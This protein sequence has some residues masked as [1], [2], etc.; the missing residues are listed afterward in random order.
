MD[1]RLLLFLSGAALASSALRPAR[2]QTAPAP[3][4][5]EQLDQ[6]LAPIALYPDAL[7]SQVLMAAT[8]PLEVVEAA[9]WSTSNPGLKGQDAV[10]AVQAFDWDVSV[11]SLVAFPEVL[12]QMNAQLDWTQKLGDA[13]IGQQQDV[14]D[15]IQR[16]R[17]EAAAAGNL[18]SG[19]Q[20][21]VT[22]EGSGDDIQYAIA[23]T[24]PDLIYVPVYNPLWVYGRWRYAAYPPFY[25]QPLPG[26]GYAALPASGFLWGIGLAVAVALFGGWTW[27]RGHSF[28]RVD[29]NRA[30]VI[31]RHFQSSRYAGNQWQHDPAHRGGVAYRTPAL[32]QQ[33]RQPP[34]GAEQRQAFRGHAEEPARPGPAQPPQA[35]HAAPA[36]AS[37]PPAPV[38]GSQHTNA[39]SGVARGPQV[40]RESQ[41][42]QAQQVRVASHAPPPPARPAPRPASPPPPPQNNRGEH[43]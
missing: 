13:M 28:M 40:S 24:D 26:F 33:Y 19:P 2:A 27:R 8:Y 17:S 6:I 5:P 39:L 23:P 34:A 10:S 7:L 29:F 32:R 16:L 31:D 14:A 3:Y 11:K 42:G 36:Q 30:A 35:V 15:S 43:R 37:R 38:P 21:T 41:R 18:P 4:T 25:W 20:D 22:T 12:G 1:R 9:R